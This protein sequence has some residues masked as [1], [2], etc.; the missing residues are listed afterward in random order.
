MEVEEAAEE[1]EEAE[2]EAVAAVVAVE[3][4]EKEED[5]LDPVLRR[6]LQ[7]AVWCLESVKSGD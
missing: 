2:A 5:C 1:A 7:P 3:E 4:K 6:H